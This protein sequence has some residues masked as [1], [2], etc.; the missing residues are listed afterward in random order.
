M[1][2]PIQMNLLPTLPPKS[3]S[4]DTGPRSGSSYGE[5]MSPIC[6]V[7]YQFDGSRKVGWSLCVP[8]KSLRFVLLCV[9]AVVTPSL[10]P[11]VI[12]ALR[13]VSGNGG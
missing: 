5:A 7:V 9:L 8:T 10:T 12:A 11:Y 4:D 2:E 13:L 3:T 6:S 1:E